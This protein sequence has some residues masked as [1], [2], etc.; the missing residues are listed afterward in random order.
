MPE[1]T[2]NP[3]Y[4]PRARSRSKLFVKP[5][6]APS[7]RNP[8]ISFVRSARASVFRPQLAD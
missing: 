4:R 5:V 6:R 2:L 1:R 8:S 7:P 3:D